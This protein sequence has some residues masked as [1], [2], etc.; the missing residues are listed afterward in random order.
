MQASMIPQDEILLIITEHSPIDVTEIKERYE[1]TFKK[2]IG[3]FDIFM[4]LDK[5]EAKK[6]VL[7]DGIGTWAM[8]KPAIKKTP[9]QIISSSPKILNPE[10]E[11]PKNQ[12]CWT[13]NKELLGVIAAILTIIIMVLQKYL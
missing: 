2:S 3:Y 4:I 8:Y 7:K 13:E 5:L 9:V 1:V 6:L 12:T 10:R 11:K